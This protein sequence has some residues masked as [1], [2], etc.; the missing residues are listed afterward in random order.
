[1][2]KYVHLICVESK[3]GKQFYV[4]PSDN[5]E[6]AEK[7]FV[8]ACGLTPHCRDDDGPYKETGRYQDAWVVDTRETESAIDGVIMFAE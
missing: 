1:M 5:K 4:A 6:L 8:S 3:Y 2:K 7:E